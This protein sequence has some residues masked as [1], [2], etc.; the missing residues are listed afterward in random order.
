M[1]AGQQRAAGKIR[2]PGERELGGQ[3]PVMKE[4]LSIIKQEGCIRVSTQSAAGGGAE[5]RYTLSPESDCSRMIVLGFP[6][7]PVL[8]SMYAC[9]CG[10]AG[11]IPD[12]GRSRAAGQLSP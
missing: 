2:T 12:P 11:L 4:N 5:H 3:V 7:R 8:K 10:R 9:Q 6:G 1:W